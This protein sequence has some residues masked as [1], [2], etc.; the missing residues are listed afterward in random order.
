MSAL[1][2]VTARRPAGND[3]RYI[4]ALAPR[5][6]TEGY[7]EGPAGAARPAKPSPRQPY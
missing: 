6:T 4:V 2:V 3:H 1:A 5:N 7:G